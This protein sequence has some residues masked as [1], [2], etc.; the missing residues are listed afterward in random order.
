MKE[1]KMPCD[2]YSRV[3][4][5]YR[6]VREWNKGKKEE[7]KERTGLIINIKGAKFIDCKW[8]DVNKLT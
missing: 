5:F 4:G 8:E 6:P 3:T 7:F 2:I 1:K